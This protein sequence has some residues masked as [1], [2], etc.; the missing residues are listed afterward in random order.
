M[1]FTSDRIERILDRLSGAVLSAI[2]NTETRRLIPNVIDDLIKMETRPERLANIAYKWCSGMYEIHQGFE[3]WEELLFNFLEIGFR[4]LNPHNPYIEP[5]LVHTEHHQGLVDIVFKSQ[6][7]EAIGDLLHAW[8]TEPGPPHTLLR[9]CTGYLVG[10][11]NLAPFSSRLQQLIIRSVEL[12]GCKGFEGVGVERFVELLNHL[13]V[14]V[15]DTNNP[16]RLAKLLVETLQTSEGVQR[17]SYRYWELLVELTILLPK[18]ERYGLA[19]SPQITTF[20]TEAQEW[21]KLECWMGIIWMVWPRGAGVAEEDLNRLMLL[22]FRQRPGA[23]QKLEKWME[24]WGQ[25]ND[26]DIPES[27]QRICKQAQEAAQRDAL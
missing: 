10:L 6:K 17:L 15:K 1:L 11:H 3:G 4:H 24:Q 16:H 5:P 19:Y 2:N 21:S 8:T 7:S 26:E 9:L 22:L 18:W 20:L 13:H 27:F 25:K 14:T 12:I 23:F